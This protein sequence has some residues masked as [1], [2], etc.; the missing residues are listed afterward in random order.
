MIF[1]YFYREVCDENNQ[2]V[3]AAPRWDIS[4][5]RSNIITLHW[6][7]SVYFLDNIEENLFSFTITGPREVYEFSI[8]LIDNIQIGV[9]YQ[10]LKFKM[11]PYSTYI[12][13][14][15]EVL[16]LTFINQ[17]K[18]ISTLASGKKISNKATSIP[19]YDQSDAIPVTADVISQSFGYIVGFGT[20]ASFITTIG[21]KIFF[22]WNFNLGWGLIN[23]IQIIAFIP[24]ASFY[25]PGNVRS[26]VS[27]LKIVN[28]AGQGMPNIDQNNFILLQPSLNNYPFNK[29]F[30]TEFSRMG[31]DKAIIFYELIIYFK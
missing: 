25:F 17:N 19:I 18:I 2:W 12:G 8:K 21:L 7:Q 20:V 23:F 27:I 10:S 24:L 5:I 4:T 9:S 15:K 6:N 13:L 31:L 3:P 28:T 22:G 1:I 26:Y 14:N 11:I 16:E 30:F 29:K